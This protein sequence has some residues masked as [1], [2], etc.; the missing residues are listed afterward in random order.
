MSY[1]KPYV[2]HTTVSE[3]EDELTTKSNIIIGL[4]ALIAICILGAIFGGVKSA[5]SASADTQKIEAPLPER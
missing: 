2:E 4:I 3:T 5:T 1:E